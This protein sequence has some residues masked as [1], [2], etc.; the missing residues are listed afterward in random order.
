MATRSE[1]LFASL[2]NENDLVALV[3]K[4][5]DTDFDCKEWHGVAKTRASLA[6]AACGFANATGG[7][8]IL[9]VIAKAAAGEPDVVQATKPFENPEVVR[10]E[11]LNVILQLV[12]PGIEAIEAR[13]IACE[14]KPSFGY[15]LIYIPASETSPH[16]S[17]LDSTFYVRIASG[18]VP[19][20]YFQVADR[21]GRRPHANLVPTLSSVRIQRVLGD[22]SGN[23][24]RII[25]VA[26]RNTGRG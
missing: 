21:F 5:E 24:Q 16:R 13:T 25:K 1:G 22:E 3:G 14:E 12:E 6:K 7:V 17:R 9:G 23:V 11:A 2:V 15:L 4:S 8:I 26:I 20:E 10:S 19:M 18:T